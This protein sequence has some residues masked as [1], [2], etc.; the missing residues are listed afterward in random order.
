MNI[1]IF[2]SNKEKKIIDERL[3]EIREN[4]KKESKEKI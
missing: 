2:V 4:T 1:T 3:K